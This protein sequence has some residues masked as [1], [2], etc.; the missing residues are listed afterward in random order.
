[1]ECLRLQSRV[2]GITVLDIKKPAAQVNGTIRP[3]PSDRQQDTK[4]VSVSVKT[5][6]SESGIE[7]A[8][9]LHADVAV[10]TIPLS[11]LQRGSIQFD[12]PLREVS[13]YAARW[14]LIVSS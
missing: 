3:S 10:V 13:A 14:L 12:P 1:M 7:E 5:R 9:V 11:M 2:D 6:T 8:E 4:G